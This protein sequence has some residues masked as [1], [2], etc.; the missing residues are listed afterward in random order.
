[1]IALLPHDL[2]ELDAEA[3]AAAVRDAPAWVAR[4]LA[5]APWAV[6]RRAAAIGV[7]L[8]IR[9][10]T[11]D[12]RYACVLSADRCTRVVTPEMLAGRAPARSLPALDALRDVRR[13]A[14][15]HAL[16]WG[17][18][19]SAGFELASGLPAVGPASD[20]DVVV[21]AAGLDRARLARFASALATVPV[22]VDVE[23]EFGDRAVALTEFST[24][25]ERMLVKT[26]Y[27]PRLVA[28]P[29]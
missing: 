4:T 2:V 7:A 24:A 5:R 19:G 26:P 3:V 11:R 17:P 27:G 29:G 12:R 8:G 20:L 16:V 22:R 18:T 14:G 9:G 25:R 10:E 21:R 6:V 15:A 23:L 1:M 13:V 28:V